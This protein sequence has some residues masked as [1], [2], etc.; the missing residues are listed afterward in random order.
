[1]SFLGK[2]QITQLK[3]NAGLSPKE[4]RRAKL[5]AKLQ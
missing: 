3:R 4:A 2:P 1:M 5:V